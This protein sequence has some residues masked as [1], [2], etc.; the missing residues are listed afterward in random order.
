MLFPPPP[1]LLLLLLLFVAGPLLSILALVPSSGFD[2][3]NDLREMEDEVFA[4]LG[5]EGLRV[6]SALRSPE[7][8]AEEGI[9]LTAGFSRRTAE[10]FPPR[11]LAVRA[12]LLDSA[13]EAAAAIALSDL[14]AE[15]GLCLA[16][17]P[18]EVAG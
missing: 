16:T 13:A 15:A 12:C 10:D 1:P 5:T 18:A 9:V 6:R 11:S 3:S 4:S 2:L 14:E 8:F 17:D 7:L